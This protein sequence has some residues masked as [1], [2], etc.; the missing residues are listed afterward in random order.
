LG[1]A[2]GLGHVYPPPVD[3]KDRIAHTI[4]TPRGVSRISWVVSFTTLFAILAFG[5]PPILLIV[6]SFCGMVVVG[7]SKDWAHRRLKRE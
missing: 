6:V 7:E 3:L 5:L 4:T 2:N 1:S